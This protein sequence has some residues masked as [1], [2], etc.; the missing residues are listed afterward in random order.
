MTARRAI[1]LEKTAK[2]CPGYLPAV[3]AGDIAEEETV[4]RVFE[5]AKIAYGKLEKLELYFK[6]FSAHEGL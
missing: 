3:V 2:L 1:E 5:T 6:A 4:V